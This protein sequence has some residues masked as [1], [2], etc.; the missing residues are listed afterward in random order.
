MLTRAL[1]LTLSV[2]IFSMSWGQ[3]DTTCQVLGV[4]SLSSSYY[5][6][7]N[8]YQGMDSLIDPGVELGDI[9]YWD[10][11]Q[12]NRV[13][14]GGEGEVLTIING[15]PLWKPSALGCTEPDACNF[16]V[17]ATVND[18]SCVEA[19]VCGVCGGPGAIYDCGC[20]SIPVGDC[21]CNGNQADAL[22]V[23]GGTCSA[24][25]DGDG[26]CDDGDDCVGQADECG[27]C[28]GPGAIYECG[29]IPIPDGYCNCAGVPD[30]DGDGICDDIDDCVGT[31]D[32]IG[33][34]NGT[35]Q[36]D[37]D[38]DG[39]CDDN[40]GDDCD[41]VYDAC[42]VC[43]GPGPIYDCGCADIPP[44]ECDCAGN[45]PDG[46][47]NCQT[48]MEDTDGDGFY[49][50]LLNPCLDQ[51]NVPYYGI[52][53]ETVA[54]GDQCW[55]QE[56]L[57]T[58]AYRN[59]DFID[60]IQDET[61]WGVA[62]QGAY[63][64]YDNDAVNGNTYGAL[65][66]WPV[67]T[68]SRHVC[69]QYWHVPTQAEWTELFDAAGGLAVAGGPLK[70]AGF[71]HWSFPNSGADNT[72]GFTA[73][74][75]GE[76]GYGAVGFVDQGDRGNWWSSTAASTAAVA[77]QMSSSSESVVQ[78]NKSLTRGQ[79]IRCLRDDPSFGC[80]DFNFLE[81]SP[82]ANIDDG[83]CSTPSIPG[84]T[85]PGFAE[86]NMAANVDNGSCETLVN[87]DPGDVVT[88]DGYDYA[89][90]AMG[91]DC[92]FA[93]NL[94]TSHYANGD[95]I[96]EI[97]DPIEWA[98]TPANTI[99]AWCIYE[100]DSA[101]LDFGCIYN[102]Y[103]VGDA[104]NI[105]PTGWHVSS[106]EDW[107]AMEAWIGMPANDLYLTNSWRGDAAHIGSV[108]KSEDGWNAWPGYDYNTTG[109]SALNAGPRQGG[110]SFGWEGN[111]SSWW[112]SNEVNST[113]AM[114][115]QMT[116][117]HRLQYYHGGINRGTQA[118][119][120]GVSVQGSKQNGQSVRCVRD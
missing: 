104:R 78:L 11:N 115:R 72:S 95:S 91:D 49:D 58:V 86:Y 96:L 85:N 50:T 14:P 1:C 70:E 68:D 90:V 67:T 3:S 10:G 112:M 94:R 44:G 54:I 7:L 105:C 117:D 77:F 28:N 39:I 114:Y 52:D 8:D 31:V 29:C 12:W 34:C 120:G 19:D 13:A 66:N 64:Y 15:L 84:C 82:T 16:D 20:S 24:D 100:N 87:C 92:W 61:A 27:V 36:T 5:Q 79:S 4:Q 106:D 25:A 41:G 62:S 63:C 60:N 89:V 69:P 42:G 21:D 103:A 47:G 56:N 30:S 102:W 51:S 33:V 43:G 6:L 81:Y 53:Y 119:G 73:L 75:G 93:E 110:G 99:G 80:T 45:L 38:G 108:I 9:L 118:G 18:G 48:F 113:T 35:C 98:N 17:N 71:A 116:Y 2:F 46:Q 26:I 59:G 76:R 37:A 74:P 101:Y 97:Q 83:S 88:F 40:G 55:F 22:G 107:L 111:V 57:N 65:Y 109:F 32:A 23:C